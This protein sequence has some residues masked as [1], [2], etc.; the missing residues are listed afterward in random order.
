MGQVIITHYPD[1]RKILNTL[2]GSLKD[3]QLVLDTKSLKNTDFETE[4]VE[5]ESNHEKVNLLY[6]EKTAELDNLK[7][8]IQNY[9]FV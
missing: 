2:Q 7:K 5:C 4:L 8:L 3:N 9:L 6:T 1:I